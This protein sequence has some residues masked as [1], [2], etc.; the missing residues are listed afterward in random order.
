MATRLSISKESTRQAHQQKVNQVLDA[1]TQDLPR[2]LS[3]DEL[4]DLAALSPFH[5]HRVFS[6]LT[7]ESPG[8][9]LIRTRLEKAAFLLRYSRTG[10]PA[11]A[12]AVGYKS[13]DSLAKAFRKRFGC[14]PQAYLQSLGDNQIG[15]GPIVQPLDKRLNAMLKHSRMVRFPPGQVLYARGLGFANGHYNEVAAQLW[16]RL[17]AYAHQQQLLDKET[18]YL[19]RFPHCTSITKPSQCHYEACIRLTRNRSIVCP[20]EF[21]VGYEPGGAFRVFT[22]DGPYDTLWESW[23]A[24]FQHWLPCGGYSL[25]P[26]ASLEVYPG[27]AGFQNKWPVPVHLYLP[28][29]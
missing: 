29:G 18:Q 24:I 22:H 26:A 11:I 27:A 15:V 20:A 1:I 28:V 25:R 4:A 21:G 10:L 9:L 3:L 14:S 6:R 7:G 19:A 16:P 23:R 17:L 8:R 5:L 13:V 2:S 12:R